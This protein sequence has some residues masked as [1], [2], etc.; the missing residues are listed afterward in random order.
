MKKDIERRS[1]IKSMALTGLGMSVLGKS[2]FAKEKKKA[3]S[4]T[5]GIIGLDTSHSPAF[6]Q[7]I[8]NPD[9]PETADFNVIAAYPYGSRDLEVSSSRIPGITETIKEMGIEIVDSI[10]E[11]IDKVDFVLLETN[12]GHPRLEQTRTVLEAGK[13]VFIDKPVA[14]SLKDTI[15]IYEACE[16]YNTPAFSS[17][18]LRYTTNAQEVR[19]EGK[20]GEVIGVDAYSSADRE[21]SHP[22]LF[23]YGIHG[24]EIIYTVLGTGCKSVIRTETDTTDIVV[25]EWNDG[26]LATLRG[27]RDGR[28]GINGTVFGT[29]SIL[30]LGPS[31]GYRP[32]VY[33]ILEFFRTGEAPVSADETIEI[34]AFMEAADESKRQGGA[35]V[36]LEYVLSNAR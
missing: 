27:I 10:D 28:G 15:A 34:Y 19:N 8:N 18:S 16:R 26:R 4:A 20:V 21:P 22:D 11:L 29:D 35:P 1:F 30:T 7:I 36:T 12:D 32:L 31:Q 33:E 25:G 14:A 2:A 13:R 6:T 23:W 17:S 5:V 9:D 3:E 24:V